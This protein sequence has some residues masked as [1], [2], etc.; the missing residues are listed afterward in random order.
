MVL[1]TYCEEKRSGNK[2]W[3][4]DKMWEGPVG[5][6]NI[7]FFSKTSLSYRTKLEYVY[8]GISVQYVNKEV[9]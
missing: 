6:C 3:F 1:G 8:K 4:C 5:I 9:L 2:C 7:C